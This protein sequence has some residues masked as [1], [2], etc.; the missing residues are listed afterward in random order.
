VPSINLRKATYDSLIM[1]GFEPTTFANSA[2][3]LVLSLCVQLNL[4][5]TEPNDKEATEKTIKEL[6]KKIKEF[7][8]VK[9]GGR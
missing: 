6:E 5:P 3:E 1:N 9:Y 8:E 7:L 2:S 4:K